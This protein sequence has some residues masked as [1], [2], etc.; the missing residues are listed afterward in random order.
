MDDDFFTIPQ[1]V[2]L[3]VEHHGN[4]YLAKAYRHT[5]N[6]STGKMETDLIGKA[7]DDNKYMALGK[8]MCAMKKFLEKK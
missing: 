2:Q 8:M 3:R 6:P 5:I 7:V 4:N 1:N